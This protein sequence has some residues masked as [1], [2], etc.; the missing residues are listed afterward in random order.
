M[1][2]MRISPSI[3]RFSGV[4]VVNAA[5][6][7]QTPE[8]EQLNQQISDETLFTNPT[9]E[10]L[11]ELA[12]DPSTHA[13]LRRVK[14]VTDQ[15]K[16]ETLR[17]LRAELYEAKGKVIALRRTQQVHIAMMTGSQMGTNPF[18][19]RIPEKK[20]LYLENYWR[21]IR[22]DKAPGVT[23]IQHWLEHRLARIES[24]AAIFN[25]RH[26]IA[27]SDTADSP[28]DIR[29]KEDAEEAQ[30]QYERWKSTRGTRMLLF[31]D[32]EKGADGTRVKSVFQQQLDTLNAGGTVNLP[33]VLP[34][35][36]LR[37]EANDA[38]VR[39]NQANLNY[40]WYTS[41]LMSAKID[42][43]DD[44]VSPKLNGVIRLALESLISTLSPD[45]FEYRVKARVN[46]Q[47]MRIKGKLVI[48]PTS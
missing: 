40:T 7:S 6:L 43:A 31:V 14:Y 33:Y 42:H 39:T 4:Y 20:A 13:L 41:T 38:H 1:F 21:I 45:K 17:A 18:V 32:D 19:V 2:F 37:Q 23:G 27:S 35:H 29:A 26:D 12:S 5:G 28:F 22:Q 15:K 11:V 44:L 25:A 3:P 47:S 16:D 34:L 30:K 8:I 46:S 24:R 48:A 10:T 36:G 9:K